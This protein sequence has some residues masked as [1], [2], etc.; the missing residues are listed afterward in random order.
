MIKTC[1]M[2]KVKTLN[3][4]NFKIT[5]KNHASSCV[6]CG[7]KKINQRSRISGWM[8]DF[9]KAKKVICVDFL[10][11]IHLPLEIP[12]KNLVFFYE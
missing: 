2:A 11:F 5:S 10:H 9:F 7:I 6:Q 12:P 3:R 4:K 1:E 8:L